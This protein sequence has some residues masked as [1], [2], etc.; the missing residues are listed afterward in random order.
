MKLFILALL[1][2]TLHQSFSGIIQ[3]PVEVAELKEIDLD[4]Q[5]AQDI[6]LEIDSL[7]PF[8]CEC[9]NLT[10]CMCC[11]SLEIPRLNL[12]R[13]CLCSTFIQR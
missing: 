5:I 1:A 3:D 10:R 11:G 4:A 2:I 7:L 6:Q 13:E 8:S 12:N 9:D